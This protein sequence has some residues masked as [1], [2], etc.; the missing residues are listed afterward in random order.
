MMLAPRSL[1]NKVCVVVGA[2]GFLGAQLCPKLV[3]CGAKVR[4]L[5]KTRYFD[6]PFRHVQWQTGNFNDVPKLAALLETADIVF[7]LAGAKTPAIAEASRLDD[8]ITNVGGSLNL[9]ELCR[10]SGIDRV[11]FASS[12]GTVY[13]D[14]ASPPYTEN[15]LPSPISTYGINKLA[16]EHYMALYNRLHGMRNVVL[17]IANPF[18]PFQHRLKNQGAIPV[19]SRLALAGETIRIW[20]DGTVTRDYLYGEDVAD[21]MIAAACYGGTEATFNIGSSIGRSLRDVIESLQEVLGTRIGVEYLPA[22]GFDAAANI[23]DS[24]LAERELAW[25]PRTGWLEALKATCDW[26][27]QDMQTSADE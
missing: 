11:V 5:G 23:L 7:H 20:G 27:R 16:V 3:A 25:R 8:L 14:T 1:A 4:A 24:S 18:G 17:R 19:F 10:K 21:A 9:L 6:Q 15:T 26:I 13:G 22:R 12:G 2:G